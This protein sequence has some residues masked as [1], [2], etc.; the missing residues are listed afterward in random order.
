MTEIKCKTWYVDI[1]LD[2]K[3]DTHTVHLPK[4]GRDFAAVSY[5]LTH[6][7]RKYSDEEW[8]RI[9]IETTPADPNIIIERSKENDTQ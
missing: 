7:L 9:V 6:R 1:T 4:P 2:G 3:T 5:L 8:E